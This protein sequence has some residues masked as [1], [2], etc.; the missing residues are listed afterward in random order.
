MDQTLGGGGYPPFGKKPN[1][2]PFVFLKASLSIVEV[3]VCFFCEEEVKKTRASSHLKLP[4]A[5]ERTV[6]ACLNLL[7]QDA[8]KRGP[9]Q[10]ET[11]SSSNV[12]VKVSIAQTGQNIALVLPVVDLQGRVNKQPVKLSA[13][14]SIGERQCYLA[15]VISILSDRST[16]GP[17]I[18][19]ARPGYSE[20]L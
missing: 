7:K 13:S 5:R 16:K 19:F 17:Y 10:C 1:Y 8:G 2:F 6:E 11:C 15:G 18:L 4:M 12:R 3:R 14:L 9:F 20:N